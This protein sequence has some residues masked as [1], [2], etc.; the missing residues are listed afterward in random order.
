M[1]TTQGKLETNKPAFVVHAKTLIRWGKLKG[2]PHSALLLSQNANYC[3]WILDQ[4]PEFRYHSSRQYI[5][6]NV[7]DVVQELTPS[8]FD[9]LSTVEREL[10]DT[11]QKRVSHFEAYLEK[12]YSE[13]YKIRAPVADKE[14]S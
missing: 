3:K 14:P 13:T 7:S 1:A 8:E 6:D 12:W 2:Q 5:V 10:T 11:E 9:H 4:G